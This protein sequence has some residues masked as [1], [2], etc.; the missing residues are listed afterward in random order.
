M[1]SQLEM[2]SGV[3]Y[4]KW[5]D[6]AP[7]STR[8]LLVV[9]HSLREEVLGLSH[10]SKAAAHIGN[11]K[12]LARLKRSFW[13]NRMSED[14][15]LYCQTCSICSKNKK[16]TARPKA[17]LVSYHAGYPMEKVHMDVLGPFTN[18]ENGNKYVIMMIDQFSKWVECVPVPDQAAPVVVEKFLIHF[19][20]TFGCPVSNGQIERQ[21]RTLL[22]MIHCL[23]DK[24]VRNW[25]K[26]LPLISMALHSM[27]NKSTG[28]SANQIMLG[29]EV[30]QPE[31]LVMGSAT[32]Q[33]VT[34]DEWVQE[35]RDRLYTIHAEV[36]EKLPSAQAYQKKYFDQ[37]AK[38]QVFEPG[39]LVY[40]I[41]KS[42]RRGVSPKLQAIYKGPFLIVKCKHPLYCIRSRKRDKFTHHNNLKPCNVP[43]WLRRAR[44]DFFRQE[45]GEEQIKDE[46]LNENTAESLRT[47]ESQEESTSGELESGPAASN[48][49]PP[50]APPEG[51]PGTPDQRMTTRGRRVKLPSSLRDYVLDRN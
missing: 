36:R 2:K 27:V 31:D 32:P 16:A 17:S 20:A 35:L 49:N 44:N 1:R 4:Y 6:L 42:Y 25:D 41:E 12:T 21:N 7:K 26:D 18:S 48:S 3:L 40:Q 39:G 5:E 24:N 14:C 9:P 33:A 30:V 11:E 10:D 19:I 46:E 8:L 23:I 43:L 51:T 15:K 45:A 29:R 50:V 47:A 28:F 22:Q 34:Q 38:E 37:N 13:W